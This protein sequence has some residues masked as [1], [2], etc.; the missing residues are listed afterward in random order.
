MKYL[1]SNSGRFTKM[2]GSLTNIKVECGGVN[3]RFSFFC[4]S[5]LQMKR[6]ILLLWRRSK[7][8]LNLRM[9]RAGSRPSRKASWEWKLR[10]LRGA[11]NLSHQLKISDMTSHST[12]LLAEIFVLRYFKSVNRV[13]KNIHLYRMI[14][15]IIWRWTWIVLSCKKRLSTSDQTLSS[16]AK[17]KIKRGILVYICKVQWKLYGL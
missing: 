15:F 14:L 6:K 12:L 11:L 10:Q 16:I 17:Q 5:V 8:E 3:L 7:K 1:K 2:H 13:N 9:A 4:F